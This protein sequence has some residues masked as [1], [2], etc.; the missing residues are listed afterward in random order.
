M[1]KKLAALLGAAAAVATVGGAQAA[2]HPNPTSSEALQASSYADLLMPVPDAV[3]ALKADN[4]AQAA[5]A[6]MNGAQV[7]QYYYHHHHHHHHHY[8]RHHH[9]H[10]YWWYRHHRRHHHHHH[11]HHHSTFFGIP[12]F[13]GVV[14]RDH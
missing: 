1:D 2:T 5:N 6:D 10:S 9:H 8:R 11:H 12:G 7:A 4:A 13:G 14:V 3:S